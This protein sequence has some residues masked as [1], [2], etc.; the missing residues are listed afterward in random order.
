MNLISRA[1]V[2]LRAAAQ[3]RAAGLPAWAQAR[4]GAG[5]AA[6]WVA[7]DDA[8]PLAFWQERV[9]DLF[10]AHGAVPVTVAA[11]ADCGSLAEVVRFAHRLDVPVT[12]RIGAAGLDAAVAAALV[13]AGARRVVVHAPRPEAFVA[14]AA[15]RASRGANVDLEAEV[16]ADVGVSDARALV[17]AGADGVRVAAGWSGAPAE[18]WPLRELIASFQRT[19]PELWQALRRMGGQTEPGAPRTGGSCAASSRLVLDAAGLHQCPWKSGGGAADWAGLA[20]QR[21][22]IRACRRECW[23]PSVR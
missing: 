11:D 13:D 22:E 23:H 7:L 21:A 5:P 2:Q 16:A 18:P 14:L 19:P 1:R 9:L 12:V 10:L 4:V 20:D 8:Q 3:R 17:A 15:A 6:L